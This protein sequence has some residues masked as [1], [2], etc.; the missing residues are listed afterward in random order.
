MSRGELNFVLHLPD[1]KL[2]QGLDYPMPEITISGPVGRLEGRFHKSEEPNAP[3]VIM[4]HHH[5]MSG[6]NMNSPV[7]HSLY[8]MFVEHKFSALRF[9]FRGVGR[10][11]GAFDYGHGELSDA[12]SVM[13]WAT[14]NASDPKAVWIV[15]YSFG[16]WVGMQLLMRRPEIKG[17]IS[18]SPP[19]NLFNFDFLSPCPSSGL[20]INGDKD[21]V[22]PT[23]SIEELVE[24]LQK[25]EGI[26][27]EHKVV[28]GANHFFEKKTDRL[29][30][31]CGDYVTS[32]IEQGT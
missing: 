11:I 14:T 13:D 5:P 31:L 3:L 8:Y 20:I 9:N 30:K 23:K 27:I 32:R 19:A 1:F 6:G 18:V 7:I 15:G 16:A 29:V 24:R 25:Q 17:F 10:S 12:A 26:G 21:K 22:V 4:L 2:Q 28:K